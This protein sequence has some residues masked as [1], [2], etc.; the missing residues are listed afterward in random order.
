M[1]RNPI[2]SKEQS[3]VIRSTLFAKGNYDALAKKLEV[4]IPGITTEI[5]E[6][7][8]GSTTWFIHCHYGA[9]I[10]SLSF[11]EMNTDIEAYVR[12]RDGGVDNAIVTGD[13]SEVKEFIKKSFEI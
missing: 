6:P 9:G 5:E 3:N 7:G 12:G 10:V 2:L 11:E 4:E 1:L 8:W 13:L